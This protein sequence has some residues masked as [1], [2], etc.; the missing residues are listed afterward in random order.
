MDQSLGHSALSRTKDTL[1]FLILE[2]PDPKQELYFQHSNDTKT[3]TC[4]PKLAPELRLKIWKASFPGKSNFAYKIRGLVNVL[5]FR[6]S[7]P[8]KNPGKV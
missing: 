4:F 1:E 8:K 5:R 3:F 6:L 2:L 7:A